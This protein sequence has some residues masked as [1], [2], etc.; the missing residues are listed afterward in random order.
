MDFFCRTL[1][2]AWANARQALAR[3]VGTK[4]EN[5]ILVDNSTYGMN[6]LAQSFHLAADDEVLLTDHEYGAVLRIWQ[7]ACRQ[8]GAK[9]PVVARLPYPAES[10]DQ[11]V[12]A[13]MAA[14]TDNTR[15][16]VISHVTSPTALILPV[17]EICDAARR[18][19]IAVCVDGPHAPAQIA[20]DVDALG[21]DFYMASCHKWL[22]APFGSGFLYVAPRH[23]H[24]IEPPVLS[25]GRLP[26]LT[27]TRWTDEFQWLG[28]RDPSAFLAIPSAIEFLESVGL[29]VFQ[30]RTHSLARYARTRL[31]ELTSLPPQTPDSPEWYGSMVNV[32]LPDGDAKSLQ[33]RL[34]KRYQIEVPVIAWKDTRSI[35][36]S[37]HLYNQISDIDRLIAALETI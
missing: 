11:L 3:F 19:N 9:A 6:V 29:S 35:R 31:T 16:L 34:W 24:T 4:P 32:P 26:P 10:R 8:A 30:R 28:T 25:W 18:R 13:L 12:D 7:R 37:C 1:E 14:V 2:P 23:Q 21:C 20:L 17:K 22:S 15:L 33:E 5:L 27:P 36:V